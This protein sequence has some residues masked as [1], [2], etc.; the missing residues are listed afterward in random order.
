MR[1][2][3]GGRIDRDICFN[4]RICK[5]CD[6]NWCCKS[7]IC[8]VSIH[9]SVKDA[10]QTDYRGGFLCCFNPRICKRC[11]GCNLTV[12]H[13]ITVSIHASVKDA[14]HLGQ[15][16]LYCWYVSIHASVKDATQELAQSEFDLLSFNPRICKRC[17]LH[18][19][20]FDFVADGFNPRICKRC[21]SG[22][23]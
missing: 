13:S 9:A 20:D 19:R 18:S 15:W 3:P 4:P 11:D 5:R 23:I 10:T 8:R 2:R 6:C 21:D 16:R 12:I 7:S 17:D 22:N 14:T 1:R